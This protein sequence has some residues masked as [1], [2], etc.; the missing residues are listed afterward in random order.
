MATNNGDDRHL[1]RS[2][3]AQTTRFPEALDPGY[4]QLDDRDL[5]SLLADTVQQAKNL[6]FYNRENQPVSNWEDFLQK[7]TL[8]LLILISKS[9][10]KRSL[11]WINS[12]LQKLSDIQTRSTIDEKQFYDD[13]SEK[14]GQMLR[15]LNNW[16]ASLQSEKEATI[17]V[18]DIDKAV[19]L[20]R[21]LNDIVAA[22]LA[23]ENEQRDE[24]IAKLQERYNN[25]WI[26]FKQIQISAGSTLRIWLRKRGNVQPHIALLITFFELFRYPQQILN[27]I[28]KRHLDYYYKDLLGFKQRPGEPDRTYVYFVPEASAN[29]VSLAA[30]TTLTG[31]DSADQEVLYKTQEAVTVSQVAVGDVYSLLISR[32]KS[33]ST[34]NQELLGAITNLSVR[35]CPALPLKSDSSCQ[36]G[37]SPFGTGDHSVNAGEVGTAENSPAG[38]LITSEILSLREGERKIT[39]K[40]PCS[41]ND[42]LKNLIK[43][44]V[45]ENYE[46]DLKDAL[47][48]SYTGEGG[49]NAI[50]GVSVMI[51]SIFQEQNAIAIEFTLSASDP[52][53][54]SYTENIHRKGIHAAQPV[55]QLSL[56]SDAAHF[57]YEILS[58]LQVRDVE[59]N[60][61]V[62]GLS[63]STVYTETGK[64][65]AGQVFSPFGSVPAPGSYFTLSN[66]ELFHKEIAHLEIRLI[67][68][69]LPVHS[70]ALNE[71]MEYFKGYNLKDE[72]INKEYA[73]IVN[74]QGDGKWEAIDSFPFTGPDE[75]PEGAPAVSV[76]SLNEIGPCLLKFELDAPDFAF[77][78]KY[79]PGALR[80]AVLEKIG[81]PGNAYEEPVPPFTPML[82]HITLDY[83]AQTKFSD[84]A[85]RLHKPLVYHITPINGATEVVPGQQA[86]DLL[87]PL[88]HVEGM[89]F[90]GLKKL[91]PAQ[92]VSLLFLI[93][94]SNGEANDNMPELAWS[95]LAKD[96]Q[97][98]P[99][100]P[101]CLLSNTTGNFRHT[102]LI[103]FFLPDDAEARSVAMSP[104]QHWIKAE[105]SR[106]LSSF[107]AITGIYAN[108]IEA[109]R[110]VSPD[111]TH[112]QIYPLP[113]GTVQALQEPVE[114]INKV[115]QPVKSFGGRRKETEK[116]FY[117]RVSERLRHRNRAVTPWDYERLVL[118]AFPDVA[119]AK[120]FPAEQTGEMVPEVKIVVFPE[121]REA[122][123]THAYQPM[124]SSPRLGSI[125]SFLQSRTAP[126]SRLKVMNPVYEQV[127]IDC[128]VCFYE[129]EKQGGWILH[130]LQEDIKDYLSPWVKTG[131][132]DHKLGE[133]LRVS[134]ISSFLQQRPYIDTVSEIRLTNVNTNGAQISSGLLPASHLWSVLTSAPEHD[135][136]E[137]T[138]P[139]TT[140]Q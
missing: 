97:W 28:N 17:I 130:Q 135:I 102:G 69:N 134:D 47:F 121:T 24:L 85:D 7:D 21:T 19:E 13:V 75:N 91:T 54:V 89:F 74:M 40:I 103:R 68:H 60:V 53:F 79:Y 100:P 72:A 109:L 23:T 106:N 39:I 95:Y 1:S 73:L 123:F 98:K 90:I 35:K 43:S 66:E 110:E 92:P 2:G 31:T 99:L 18:N 52:A 84:A 120:C 3:T 114:G 87:P 76:I 126:F 129:P 94:E 117:A 44:T 128:K 107:H 122:P 65:P 50:N 125:A 108:A 137:Y 80:N 46:V 33:V 25:L 86:S 55:L 83:E 6:W 45:N 140:S 118:D 81:K 32:D 139:E 48:L 20:V 78:H 41:T 82:K 138:R 64:V 4:F 58:N 88:S 5:I 36:P 27:S 16:K 133:G 34:G 8:I 56:N 71:L 29:P 61:S 15:W 136:Q 119:F 38:I 96:A 77:G 49:W 42:Y 93:N 127:K 12:V 132:Y 26:I 30:G 22:I 10:F 105:I 11:E 57:P 37:W 62:K 115:M 113:A 51:L 67:W 116:A 63:N 131:K 70:I 124:L 111:D 9:D 112:E 59:I 101:G 14:S 104:A